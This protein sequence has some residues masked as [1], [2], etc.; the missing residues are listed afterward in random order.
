MLYLF[1]DGGDLVA[2]YGRLRDDHD[3]THEIFLHE[4][5]SAGT[6]SGSLFFHS[7]SSRAPLHLINHLASTKCSSV[8]SSSFVVVLPL[9]RYLELLHFLSLVEILQ[10]TAE[11]M[12][13]TS[14]E[15]NF[16]LTLVT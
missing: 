13:M 8:V 2:A 7:H 11:E 4:K 15:W 16:E 9:S 1:L 12:R 10:Y 14:C 5:I 6:L 3:I